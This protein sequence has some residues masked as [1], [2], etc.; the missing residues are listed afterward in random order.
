MGI[1]TTRQ[2]SSGLC[3]EPTRPTIDS[4]KGENALAKSGPRLSQ[5]PHSAEESDLEGRREAKRQRERGGREAERLNYMKLISDDHTFIYYMYDRP[6]GK[7]QG[8]RF[9]RSLG[10]IGFTS[11]TATCAAR[12]HVL[13]GCLDPQSVFPPATNDQ[14]PPIMRSCV[15]EIDGEARRLLSGEIS[16]EEA[17]LSG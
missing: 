5:G 6:D 8:I 12:R 11:P 13:V 14:M 7:S 4:P 16:F 10:A 1:F 2:A 9:C 15:A 3:L 17:L